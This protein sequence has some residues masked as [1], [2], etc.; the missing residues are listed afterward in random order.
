MFGEKA[1]DKAFII[2]FI[3]LTTSP[4]ANPGTPH[5]PLCPPGS[6]PPRWPARASASARKMLARAEPGSPAAAATYKTAVSPG[7]TRSLPHPPLAAERPPGWVPPPPGGGFGLGLGVPRVVRLGLGAQRH[8]HPVPQ[9]G[10][11]A[12]T[13]FEPEYRKAPAFGSSGHRDPSFCQASLLR[14]AQSQRDS[15]HRWRAGDP[16][17][18]PG[19]TA[20]GSVGVWPGPRGSSD[21]MRGSWP[22]PWCRKLCGGF[23]SLARNRSFLEESLSLAR[24]FSEGASGAARWRPAV[25]KASQGAGHSHGSALL[26]SQGHPVSL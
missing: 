4:P 1:P 5:G 9:P 3:I 13:V 21:E 8:P 17:S 18:G 22:P 24:A 10:P 16:S 20:V 12:W 15:M 6:R 14:E 7:R 23:K 19:R 11:A 26:D 25:A 2:L